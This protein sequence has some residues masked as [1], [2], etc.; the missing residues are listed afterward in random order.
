MSAIF[1][2]IAVSEGLHI[3]LLLGSDQMGEGADEPDP[4]RPQEK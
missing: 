1:R 3:T 2:A 4:D